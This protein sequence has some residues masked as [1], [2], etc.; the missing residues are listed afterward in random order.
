MKVLYFS[1]FTAWFS[2]N[3]D[4]Q[5][6]NFDQNTDGISCKGQFSIYSINCG[7]LFLIAGEEKYFREEK[8]KKYSIFCHFIPWFVTIDTKLWLKYPLYWF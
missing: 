7:Q 2:A 5:S 3:R 6:S 8:Y 4:P 1:P